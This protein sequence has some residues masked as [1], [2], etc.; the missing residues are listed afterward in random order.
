MRQREDQ[1]E[2]IHGGICWILRTIIY[3]KTLRGEE[4]LA[5]V[6]VKWHAR[7]RL[8]EPAVHGGADHDDA[9]QSAVVVP[10]RRRLPTEAN[11]TDG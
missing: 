7:M 8:L 4:A 2:R 10:R 9:A 6:D 1:S 11:Q 3:V 5:R